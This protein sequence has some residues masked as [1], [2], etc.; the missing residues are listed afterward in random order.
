MTTPGA[1]LIL[2]WEN[3]SDIWQ[4]DVYEVRL[5]RIIGEMSV[6]LKDVPWGAYEDTECADPLAKYVANY[7]SSTGSLLVSVPNEHIRRAMRPFETCKILFDFVTDDGFPWRN[8]QI[9]IDSV[10]RSEGSLSKRIVTNQCGKAVAFLMHGACVRL[11]P[12]GASHAIEVQ[13][14]AKRELTWTELRDLG[15]K[16]PVDPRSSIGTF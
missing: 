16:A 2:S 3:P 6:V 8:R 13:I 10:D 4:T 15:S 12:F 5:S 9:A 11:L 14:P 7:Y 1:T